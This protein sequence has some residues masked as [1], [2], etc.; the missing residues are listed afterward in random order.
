MWGRGQRGNNVTCP[1]LAPLSITSFTLNKWIVPFQVLIPRWVDLC[2]YS[3]IS[4]S[5]LITSV[6]NCASDRLAISSLLSCIFSGALICSFIWAIFFFVLTG[7]L[8]SKGW[9]LGRATHCVAV[10][11]TLCLCIVLLY[12][13]EGSERKQCC[14]LGSWLAFSDLPYYSEANWALLVL[15]PGQVVLCAL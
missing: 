3:T 2:P 7:L 11:N 14:L 1:A 10:C 15:I 6:L 9:N 4:V 12:V 13:G 5:I 8:C